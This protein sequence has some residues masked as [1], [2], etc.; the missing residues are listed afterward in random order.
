MDENDQHIE[1]LNDAELAW[2][3]EELANAQKLV[4]KHCPG[5][6]CE[7]LTPQI[8]DRAYARAYESAPDSDAEY[9]NAVI[10]AIGIAFG[11]HLVDT[12]G[13]EWCAVFDAHGQE[14]AVVA[15]PDT[16]KMLVFPPNLVA[17]RWTDGTTD[18]LTYVDKGI[19]DNH[20][21]F[22][23][24]WRKR[25]GRSTASSKYSLLSWIRGKLFSNR[26]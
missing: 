10:N 19:Q 6:T 13:F 18:F 3:T 17:K 20:S 16:A 11:Q 7:A 26:G 22:R 1:P 2:V 24:H 15:F 25:G 9:A 5:V 4:A 23:E 21:L 14:L 8:L 12:L